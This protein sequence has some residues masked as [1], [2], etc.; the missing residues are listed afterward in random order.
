MPKDKLLG[1][2]KA[3]ENENKTRAKSE[4]KTRTRTKEI[5]E[6]LKKLQ[7]KF[8][9]SKIKGLEKAFMK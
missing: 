6:G 3:S 4:N 1:A 8:S 7:H 5:R 9:K 2:L